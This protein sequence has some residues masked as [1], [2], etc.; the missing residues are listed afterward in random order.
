M[1]VIRRSR[2]DL[3]TPAETAIRSAIADVESVGADVRLTD[4]VTL[5][6]A[7]QTRVADY[8][9]KVDGV[10]TLPRQGDPFKNER[11]SP[12][13][14]SHAARIMA[15]PSWK[16]LARDYGTDEKAWQAIRSVS[17]S[18]VTQAKDKA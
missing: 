18:A 14:A 8:V 15:A 4:A 5:M 10:R 13:V 17:A 3:L 11:T 9:D 2:I 7:A 6:S 16:H 1:T 12:E